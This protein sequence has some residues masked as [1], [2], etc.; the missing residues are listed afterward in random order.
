MGVSGGEIEVVRGRLSEERADQILRFWAHESRL[1]EAEARRRLAEVV[2][3]FVDEGGEVAGV[4]SVYDADIELL[5]GRRMWVYRSLLGP[6]AEPR[7][8][9]M[10]QF[11]FQALDLEFRPGRQ[12]PIGLAVPIAADQHPGQLPDA[13]WMWPR[14]T[15]A[16]RFGDGRQL[17][18]RYFGGARL[19]EPRHVDEHGSALKGH[20]Y[21]VSAF[22]DQ[23][24]VGPAD[25]IALWTSEAGLDAEEAKRRVDE[26][27]AVGTDSDGRLVAVATA[28]L[29]HNE[30]VGLDLWYF[31]AFVSTEHRVSRVASALL[32]YAR[33]HLE[34]RWIGGHEM[35]AS[36]IVL[37]VENELLK[38]HIDY[39]LW[40]ESDFIYIGENARGDHV[41]VHWF[42]GVVTT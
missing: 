35:R 15:Y 20:G 26:V 3:V 37:E 34:A 12:G 13:E 40:P 31:R 1:D 6:E 29:E 4:N 17:R 24:A 18:I 27:V 8:R 39:P 25:V 36:G 21:R 9:E 32:M 33:D 10:I 16:G 14:L 19:G 23:D 28:Y 38:R 42:P 5:A 22:A 11:T 41:R 2:C 30:Q 7:W